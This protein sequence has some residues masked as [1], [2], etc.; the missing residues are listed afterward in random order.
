MA[1]AGFIPPLFIQSS[2]KVRLRKVFA[3]TQIPI[4]VHEL[5]PAARAKACNRRRYC[6]ITKG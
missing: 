6:F 5:D 3:L 2:A 1:K 4:F